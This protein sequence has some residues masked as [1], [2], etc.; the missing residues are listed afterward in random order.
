M[1][2]AKTDLK[3]IFRR[4]EGFLGES[5]KPQSVKAV[6]EFAAK[7]IVKRTRLGY[8]VR[9]EFAEKFQLK[10]IKWSKRYQAYRK[11]FQLDPTTRPTK[12][13]LTLTGQMLR[14][15]GI[16]NYRQT[17]KSTKVFIGPSGQRTD[18][19]RTNAQIAQYNA[20]RGRIFMNVSELEYRQILRFYRKSFGDLFKKRRLLK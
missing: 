20:D 4:I 16:L 7:L 17:L 8:G 12:H 3:A 10:T 9:N 19:D 15:V 1:S 14:S 6:G 13:N 11:T 5:I 2:K 18:N